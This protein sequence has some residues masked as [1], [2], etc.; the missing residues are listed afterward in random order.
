MEGG[1]LQVHSRMGGGHLYG[2]RAPPGAFRDGRGAP[3][4]KAGASRCI[5]GWELSTCTLPDNTGYHTDTAMLL[6]LLLLLLPNAATGA[7]T[8]ATPDAAPDAAIVADPPYAATYEG[9]ERCNRYMCSQCHGTKSKVRMKH[10]EKPVYLRTC[11]AKDGSTTNRDH[12]STS[13][14]K[15]CS[16]PCKATARRKQPAS[17]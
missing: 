6:L 13:K 9:Y 15:P 4:W 8:D 14:N 5:Q 11:S 7:A 16:H 17:D 1:R 3:V 10:L 2:R 12:Q